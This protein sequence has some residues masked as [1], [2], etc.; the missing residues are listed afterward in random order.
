AQPLGVAGAVPFAVAGTDS[1]QLPIQTASADH[2]R[3]IGARI[4]RGRGFTAVDRFGTANVVVLSVALAER[5]WPGRDPIG[6]CIRPGSGAAPCAT[7]VGVVEN[8]KMEDLSDPGMAYYL[9]IEQAD[10]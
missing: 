6:Q 9:P 8:I 10:P 1:V 4:V 2:F 3:T 5:F 7:V